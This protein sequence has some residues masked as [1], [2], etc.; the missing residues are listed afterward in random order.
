MSLRP[1]T[2]ARSDERAA[3]LGREFDPHA[4]HILSLGFGQEKNYTTILSLPLIQ[5][6]Q[7]SIAGERMC[8]MY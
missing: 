2:L 3:W 8:N 6:G 4:R 7:L 5:E 1:G